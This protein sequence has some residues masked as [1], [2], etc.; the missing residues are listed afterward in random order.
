MTFVAAIDQGTTSTKGLLVGP[1]GVARALGGARHRQIFPHAGWVEHDGAELL[2]NVESI[3]AEGIAGGAT[4]IALTNQ[5]E[6]VIAW[7]RRSGTPICN[8]IVWQDQ[9]TA[10]NVEALRATGVEDEVRARAGLPLD[11]YFS[12]TKL[13]WIL[14]NVAEAHHLRREGRLGLGTSD[15]YFLERLTGRYV[16]DVT[17][18]ARTSLMN[19]DSCTWDPVLCELFG[20]PEELLPEI[21]ECDEP[22]GE[23]RGAELSVSIVDQ[24]AALYGHGCRTAGDMKVT[25]GTGAFALMV[26]DGRPKVPNVVHTVCWGGP[27]HRTYAADGG[28]YTAGA[29]IEWLIRIGLLESVG[30]LANLTGAPAVSKGVCFVPALAGLACPHWDRTAT[31]L[32]IG[33]DSGTERE[34]LIKAVLE[35]I[36]FRTVEVI[37]ALDTDRSGGILSVDGG[38]TRSR[39]FL[40]F[41]SM[42]AGRGVAVPASDELTALGAAMLASGDSV[43]TRQERGELIGSAGAD[44]THAWRD[45]FAAAR[46][47]TSGWRKTA[48]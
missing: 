35:G 37:E 31:G 30:Q 20:V 40:D 2:A 18:A 15:A 3:V 10:G 9:R 43:R 45:C 46:Q 6:T 11:A 34:D 14:G 28:V 27:A 39:Y 26:S 17:T 12:A 23:V 5:G 36:A 38:L 13:K 42:I 29:A 8:A 47:R 33:F 25:F 44:E 7:D 32:W 21:V 41:F 4:S 16:T 24:V 19:L 1:E 48:G 22:V